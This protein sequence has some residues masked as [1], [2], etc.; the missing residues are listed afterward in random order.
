MECDSRVGSLPRNTQRAM[1]KFKY[2][3]AQRGRPSERSLSFAMT[4]EPQELPGGDWK[5]ISEHYWRSGTIVP[6]PK[7]EVAQRSRKA[8][9]FVTR[10][11]FRQS[12]TGRGFWVQ[13]GPYGLV[14]D[15]EAAVPR[16]FAMAPKNPNFK[17]TATEVMEAVVHLRE[18]QHT[19][20]EERA[21]TGSPK[22]PSNTKLVAGN[23]SHVVFAFACY[24]YGAGWPWDDVV[25]LAEMQA[26]KIR[27]KLSDV[28]NGASK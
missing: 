5:M 21:S 6:N 13:V 1:N 27:S 23:V 19:F 17:G 2:V 26:D 9:G 11:S 4:L 3:L 22:G 10:R 20:A 8:G 16:L 7:S 18:V 28:A 24:E 15:A 12:A 14:G 25:L